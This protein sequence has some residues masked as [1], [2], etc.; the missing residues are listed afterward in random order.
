MN[1][2]CF[3]SAL[4]PAVALA[5][6]CLI[7]GCGDGN[8]T[9]GLAVEQ[10]QAPGHVAAG[11]GTSGAV[12]ARAP[13]VEK[14]DAPAGTPGIPQGSGGNTSGAALGG[15]TAAAP[16]QADREKQELAASMEAIAQRWRGQAAKNGWP[17]HP[18][19]PVQAVAGFDAS[20]NQTSQSGQPAGRLEG[21][22]ARAPVTSEKA[23]TAAPSSDVKDDSMRRMPPG[24]GA[25]APDRVK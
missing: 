5:T 10:T 18:A 3:R 15:T 11:G 23:G 19:T 22:A 7:A 2:V 21:E 13:R 17:S 6:A 4:S 20:A 8:R 16:Q 14:G 24:V 9:T 12:I 1:R 25:N